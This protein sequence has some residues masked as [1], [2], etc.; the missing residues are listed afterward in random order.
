M[1][2]FVKAILKVE[3]RASVLWSVH[4]STVSPRHLSTGSSIDQALFFPAVPR[5]AYPPIYGPASLIK[6]GKIVTNPRT[7]FHELPSKQ[8]F[9][10]KSGSTASV[11]SRALQPD[12]RGTVEYKSH[13]KYSHKANQKTR[14]HTSSTKSNFIFQALPTLE[15]KHHHAFQ[16]DRHRPRLERLPGRRRPG[17][18]SRPRE[19]DRQWRDHLQ[20][21]PFRDKKLCGID[22]GCLGLQ[23]H[24]LQMGLHQLQV[25]L[26]NFRKAFPASRNRVSNILADTVLFSALE[27]AAETARLALGRA[28]LTSSAP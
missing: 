6:K 22:K 21:T 20:K 9:G 23:W 26:W 1:P 28:E 17:C 13:E 4:E 14:P 24:Q 2:V 8:P 15:T 16:L 27:L 18:R 10:T 3:L 11:L 7:V 12:G 25:R 19:A 5:M